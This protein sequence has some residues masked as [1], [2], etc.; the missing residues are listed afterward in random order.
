MKYDKLDYEYCKCAYE[1]DIINISNS[2]QC[3]CNKVVINAYVHNSYRYIS[4]CRNYY[5]ELF[6]RFH[7][8][9][10]TYESDLLDAKAKAIYEIVCD[11][12]G[13][14]LFQNEKV[15]RFQKINKDTFEAPYFGGNK[16][17]LKYKYEYGRFGLI[18]TIAAQLT[19]K[20]LVI[21]RFDDII[22]SIA[23]FGLPESSQFLS[24]ELL[25]EILRSFV[26]ETVKH[27]EGSS[28]KYKKKLLLPFIND[29]K[30]R[31]SN[32][33]LYDNKNTLDFCQFMAHVFEVITLKKLEYGH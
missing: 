24:T 21:Y 18:P 13:F 11:I 10:S 19:D 32:I 30:M 16:L 23:K 17:L 29:L 8:N 4:V 26:D 28:C 27:L 20:I 12:Y 9:R 7:R 14:H 15:L 25:L 31:R 3:K 33:N 6:Q 1:T 5:S 22:E 2:R